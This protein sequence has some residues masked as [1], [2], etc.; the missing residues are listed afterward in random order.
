[1]G[2]HS[3]GIL[4]SEKDA[5]RHFNVKTA[6][7]VFLTSF[8]KAFFI[9]KFQQKVDTNLSHE[10]FPW[11][12]HLTRF[13]IFHLHLKA[14][15]IKNF[16]LFR[17]TLWEVFFYSSLIRLGLVLREGRGGGKMKTLPRRRR[18]VKDNAMNKKTMRRE[19]LTTVGYKSIWWRWWRD[20]RKIACFQLIYDLVIKKCWSASHQWFPKRF[21][22]HETRISLKRRYF[23]GQ[24]KKKTSTI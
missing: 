14:K 1:M 6:F 18:S 5:T 24:T 3:F 19:A 12:R 4:P 9:K 13:S 15:L 11:A 8:D 2:I 21:C 16:I 20:V 7:F 22:P 17:F 23:Y 10:S